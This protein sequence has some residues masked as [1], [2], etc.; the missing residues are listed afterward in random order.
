MHVGKKRCCFGGVTPFENNFVGVK[1]ERIAIECERD[2]VITSELRR[3]AVPYDYSRL[4]Y[5]HFDY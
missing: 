3:G 4:R 5:H 2:M 1:P